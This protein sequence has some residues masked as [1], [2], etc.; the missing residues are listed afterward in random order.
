MA[1]SG[2]RHHY[3]VYI[4]TNWRK[5]VLYTGVTNNLI[6]RLYE[7]WGNRG[8]PKTFAGKHYCYNLIYYEEFGDIH[9]AIAREKQIKS[10]SRERKEEL[11]KKANSEW[12][13]FNN[14]ICGRWPPLPG[15]IEKRF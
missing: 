3:Y 10:W 1:G 2:N 4:I 5:T 13:F 11:I 9:E 14:K 6:Q 8:T 15:S 12:L 7:H